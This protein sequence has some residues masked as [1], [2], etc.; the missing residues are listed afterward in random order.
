MFQ[1]IVLVVLWVGALVFYFPAKGFAVAPALEGPSGLSIV[2]I[3]MT[4]TEFVMLQNNTGAP[5]MDL[6]S[7]WLH[8]FNNVNPLAT[9]V[10]SSSQQLPAGILGE[11][12]TLLLSDGGPTCGAAITA[13]LSVGLTDSTGY[14]QIFKSS[15]AGGILSQAAGDGVSWTSGNN[16]T[17]GMISSVPSNTTDP[18]AAWYR[19]KNT[20]GS[21]SY[22]WQRARLDSNDRC[23]LNVLD[24]SSPGPKNPGNQLLPGTPP[25]AT[26]ISI[27]VSEDGKKKGPFMPAGNIGLEAP[28]LNE[29]LPNPASPQRD[30]DDEF[31]EL[32]NPNNKP[33]DLTGFKLQT[34]STGSGS[35]RTY[36]FPEGTLLKSKSFAAYP[37]S[38]ISISLN[39]SGAQIMLLDPFDEVISQTE[40]YGK[41]KDGWS[42]ALAEGKWYWTTTPTPGT[43]NTISADGI[44]GGSTSAGGVGTVEG[45]STTGTAHS[46]AAGG[47]ANTGGQTNTL[48]PGVLVGVAA[49]ALLYGLYEYR[50]D[51]KNTIYRIRRDGIFRRKNRLQ[52]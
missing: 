29:L 22:L 8:A 20:D 36:T 38:N 37:S 40:P 10:N 35:K 39:N 23:Q 16:P 30:A 4:G 47:S 7:Y 13:N 34:V 21:P 33:F 52:S 18:L 46:S 3:K 27:P 49:A 45:A 2:E 25:P 9:G 48:H 50:G 41:A 17:A 28:V 14:L 12:Q 6:S 1:K 19:Y 5:I 11:G 42:W 51:I 24:A 31:I 44:S 43:Q 15:L 32:Y 26:I